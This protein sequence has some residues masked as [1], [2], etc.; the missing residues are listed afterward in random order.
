MVDSTRGLGPAPGIV[1]GG[2]TQNTG[3]TKRSDGT[4]E[5]ERVRDVIEISSEA[6]SAAQAEE[7]AIETRE[8][9]SKNRNVT[10]GYNPSLLDE[11]A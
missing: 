8:T 11:T 5:P 9:I 7:T 10:L 6:L 4:K 2:K 1:P 3:T